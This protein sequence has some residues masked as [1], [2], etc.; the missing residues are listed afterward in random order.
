MGKIAF[1]N[2]AKFYKTNFIINDKFVFNHGVKYFLPDG[3]ILIP[4]YHP[5][6]RNV[7]T[8]VINKRMMIGL[9]KMA[10]KYSRL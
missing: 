4:S 8:K 3:K 10:K 9:L 5:S 2:C 7:N 1:D 6:P